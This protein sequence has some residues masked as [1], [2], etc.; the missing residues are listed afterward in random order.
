[1]KFSRFAQ[2]FSEDSGIVQLMDDLGDAMA[3][4]DMLMLGGGNPSYIPEV[5]QYFHERLERILHSPAEF[6]HVIGDYDS[7]QGDKEFL[8]VMANFLNEQYQWGLSIK[9]IALCGGSQAGFY[10]LFN[11]FSGELTDGRV[12]KIC[13]PMAPEYIGYSSLTLNDAG[14]ISYKPSIEIIDHRFFKYHVDLNALNIDES[15]GAICLSRPTNP[16]G[17]VITDEEL[18]YL[19]D[20]AEVND[21]PLI[22]DNA[23]GQ[24]FPNIIFED[25]KPLWNENI[26]LCMSLSKLGLPGA[27]TG[28]IVAND[29]VIEHITHMNAIC[30]LSLGSFGPALAKDLIASG[31]VIPVSKMVIQRFYQQKLQQV[32]DWI[33]HYFTGFEF[34]IHKPEGA[35]FLWLWFPEL[36]I[37]SKTLYERLKQK[38]VLV[39]PGEE[40]FPGLE[41]QWQHKYECIRITYSQSGDIVEQGL[42]IIAD[43]LRQIFSNNA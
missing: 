5:Q 16:T 9:N 12:A 8:E 33:E 17:N 11:L 14:L 35:I 30:N 19:V 24:P 38:G 10:S 1:M 21:I 25:V 18:N 4:N 22:I 41:E 40:F 20:L 39:I 27:R 13:L 2:R 6:C 23:Y 3:G 32:L 36:P 28:I 26:I 31:D 7:P 34:Y 37:T 43:E 42:K 15:I 29:E